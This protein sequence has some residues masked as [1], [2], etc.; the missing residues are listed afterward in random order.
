MPVLGGGGEARQQLP[1]PE[2]WLALPRTAR[3]LRVRRDL[4]TGPGYTGAGA[5]AERRRRR[6]VSRTARGVVRAVEGCCYLTG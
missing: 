4:Q 2:Y 3:G 5:T 6:A 1:T